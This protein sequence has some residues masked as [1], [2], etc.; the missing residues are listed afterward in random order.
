[1]NFVTVVFEKE[2]EFLKTQ[3]RSIDLYIDSIEVDSILVV[4]NDHGDYQ[5]DKSWWGQHQCRVDIV[6]YKDLG[7]ISD[8]MQSRDGWNRQQIAKLKGAQHLDGQTVILDAKT[9]F[10]QPLE[11]RRFVDVTGKY[12][13]SHDVLV[14]G[15]FQTG[16]KFISDFFSIPYN[17]MMRSPSGVPFIMEKP[18]IDA[19]ESFIIEKTGQT[20][21]SFFEKVDFEHQVTEFVMYSSFLDKLMSQSLMPPMTYNNSSH[22]YQF[23]NLA[24][25]YSE[26]D[27]EEFFDRILQSNTLTVSIHRDA[28]LCLKSEHLKKW[29]S[30]LESKKLNIYT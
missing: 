26:H 18:V 16:A 19:M 13:N 28:V 25:G 1:M 15:V 29:E 7:I 11:K 4:T 8:W 14:P 17:G 22:G 23:A 3:S 2:L 24:S 27:A 21:I 6:N 5:I 20:L 12:I 30:F 10:C 9:W